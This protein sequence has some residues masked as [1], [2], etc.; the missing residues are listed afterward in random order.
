MS[1]PSLAGLVQRRVRAHGEPG[2]RVHLEVEVRGRGAGVT[3]VADVADDLAGLHIPVLGVAVEVGAVVADAVVAVELERL[4]AAR[5]RVPRDEP[6][7]GS[8]DRRA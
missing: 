7:D 2:P 1:P 5:V 3:A 8:H 4:A 6:G